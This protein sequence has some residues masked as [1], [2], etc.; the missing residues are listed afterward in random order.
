MP[1]VSIHIEGDAARVWRE[2]IDVERWPEWTASVTSIERLDD[3]PFA[4]GSRARIRQPGMPAGIWTVTELEPERS[5]TWAMSMPG[6]AS[7]A[8]HIL[9]ATPAGGVDLML[10]IDQRG[11]LAPLV[12]RLG[13]RRTVRLMTM[14]A[15]GLKRQVEQHEPG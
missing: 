11:L 1:E 5:F 9:T 15:E 14:E 13:D 2:M 6:V 10:T 4:V 3:G 7:T 8:E 12:G